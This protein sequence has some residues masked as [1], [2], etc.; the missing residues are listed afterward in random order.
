[1]PKDTA[2]HETTLVAATFTLGRNWSRRVGFT[3]ET[4]SFVPPRGLFGERKRSFLGRS[5][6]MS[7]KGIAP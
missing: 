3:F 6:F 1:M 2:A 5:L 4:S 7:D